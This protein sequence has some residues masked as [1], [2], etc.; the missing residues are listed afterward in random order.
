VD[1]INLEINIKLINTKENC[2]FQQYS[3]FIKHTDLTQPL[4]CA[5]PKPGPGFPMPIYRF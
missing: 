2:Y 4:F 5:C 3:K 1:E